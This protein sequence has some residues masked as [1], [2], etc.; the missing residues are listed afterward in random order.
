MYDGEWRAS[1]RHGKGTH[2]SADGSLYVGDWH[3]DERSGDGREKQI[4][5][6]EQT[7]QVRPARGAAHQLAFLEDEALRA[8]LKTLGTNVDHFSS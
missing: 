1:Q 7:A 8:A 5:A 4:V 2:K 3:C 6:M